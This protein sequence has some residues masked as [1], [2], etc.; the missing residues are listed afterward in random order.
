VL[1]ETSRLFEEAPFRFLTVVR[2][3]KGDGGE[4]LDST[5]AAA[6]LI[7]HSLVD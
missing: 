6:L 7:V 2:V 5:G 4:L 3:Q 1:A